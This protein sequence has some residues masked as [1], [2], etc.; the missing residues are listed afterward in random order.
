MSKKS[1]GTCSKPAM[2]NLRFGTD[3]KT[4]D[5]SACYDRTVEYSGYAFRPESTWHKETKDGCH[6]YYDS[7]YGKT[8][9]QAP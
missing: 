8:V 4:A 6:I 1:H 3:F 9:F 7:V 5:Q 2:K